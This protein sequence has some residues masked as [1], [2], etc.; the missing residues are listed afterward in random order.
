MREFIPFLESLE[1]DD[2]GL[3]IGKNGTLKGLWVPTG[4][5]EEEEVPMSIVKLIKTAVGIDISDN[6]NYHTIH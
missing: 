4:L 2:Y 5:T 3:I 6:N 1:D